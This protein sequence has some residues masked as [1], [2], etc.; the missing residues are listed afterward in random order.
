MSPSAHIVYINRGGTRYAT[1]MCSVRKGKTT[2]KEEGLYLGRVL[3][4]ERGIYKTNTRGIFSF[5]LESM[6]CGPAP[7]D[8]VD[9]GTRGN[10]QEE[11][12][13]ERIVNFGDTFLPHELITRYV[14]S[15][16]CAIQYDNPDSLKALLIYCMLSSRSLSLGP[17]WY[18]G[19]YAHIL[20]PQA[21][22]T[23]NND[24]LACIGREDAQQ[25]FFD[26]Y[27]SSLA[28]QPCRAQ[29]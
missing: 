3:D 24:L 18:E 16:I 22:L 28:P 21:D 6:T 9:K 14:D 20:Y 13:E 5:D 1:V 12:T 4:A 29:G 2:R 19:S 27:H 25:R 23:N 17:V 11:I 26:A 7:A 15:A 8:F 10:A